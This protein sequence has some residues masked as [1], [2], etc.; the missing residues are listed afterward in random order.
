MQVEEIF[1][2]DAANDQLAVKDVKHAL[3]DT[4]YHRVTYT[5][6]GTT[7]YREYFPASVLANPQD[8]VR[9]TPAE[10]GTPPADNARFELD[11]PSS[12]R[13]DAVKPLYTLPV[14]SWSQSESA[15]VITRKRRGGGLRLYMERPWFSSGAG[16]LLGVLL[17]PA[18]YAPLSADWKA[19]RKYASEWGMDPLWDATE[20]APLAKGDF[21]NAVAD[22]SGLT[23]AELSGVDVD[24]AAFEP[25]YDTERNLWFCDIALKA[26]EQYFPF[27]RLALAR[28]QP[29]SVPNAHLSPVV[30]SDFIQVLPHRTVKYD[31]TQVGVTG[32]VGLRVNGPAYFNRQREQLGT[33]LV[34]AR[35]E[36]RRF[37]TGDALGWEPVA[38]QAIP[39][40]QRNAADTVWQGQ[41][42]LP[43]PAP[44][45]LRILVLEA[46]I[47][48]TDPQARLEAESRLLGG[49]VFPA[50]GEVP[51]SA[52]VGGQNLGYRIT[53]ADSIEL[54]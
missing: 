10:V 13:P 8:L 4:K 3:G 50:A 53:F 48:A 37:D 47:Y 42:K 44:S 27:V 9:P 20:T 6:I 36:R 34:V 33:P 1:A 28:Y 25:Q 52:V 18:K 22:D 40:V 7:R 11:V 16:E 14:F 15:G 46:E 32:E 12:A 45:P 23:I 54:P 26:P 21:A 39:V 24:V 51:S 49:E 38:T 29:I 2:P 5:A 17:R 43:S 31:T 19:L 41:L 35:V 30:P